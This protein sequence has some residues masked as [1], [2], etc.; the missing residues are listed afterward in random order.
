ML[1]PKLQSTTQNRS[2]SQSGRL[3]ILVTCIREQIQFPS[4]AYFNRYISGGNV[5]STAGIEFPRIM[6]TGLTAEVVNIEACAIHISLTLCSMFPLLPLFAVLSRVKLHSAHLIF[7]VLN[8]VSFS[9]NWIVLYCFVLCFVPFV[10]YASL[11][12]ASITLC[13]RISVSSI[14]GH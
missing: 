1:V 4:P 5:Q 11:Y 14:I 8:L 7:H 9:V 12:V 13:L 6:N 2:N 3:S 10:L